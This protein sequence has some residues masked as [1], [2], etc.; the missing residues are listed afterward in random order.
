MG[1][2]GEEKRPPGPP[3]LASGRSASRLS[4]SRQQV[5]LDNW[6]TNSRN[7][8]HVRSW[9]WADVSAQRP[10]NINRGQSALTIVNGDDG[11]PDGSKPGDCHRVG[12]NQFNI[13]RFWG[14]PS[15]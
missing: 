15:A 3:L 7:T 4:I 5:T 13:L 1:M 8:V 14:I 9:G 6:E 2:A 12:P 11:N 10:T